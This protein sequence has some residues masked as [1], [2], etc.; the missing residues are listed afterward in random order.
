MNI[1]ITP[2]EQHFDKGYG[3]S[4]WNF[5]ESAKQLSKYEYSRDLSS[6][7]SYLQRHAIELYLKSIIYILHKKYQ[8]PF[9]EAFNLANPAILVKETWKPLSGTHDLVKLYEYLVSVLN[10]CSK[11]LPKNIDWSFTPDIDTKINLI[12][13]Y[14]PKSTYFRY[15][16]S[17]KNNPL[18]QKKST[19]QRV[20]KDSFL[21]DLG[22]STINPVKCTIML[23]AEDNIVDVYDLTVEPL[24]DVKKA[25]G[26]IVEEFHAFH[27]A[28]LAELTRFS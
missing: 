18:D 25:L 7:I 19:V 20:N 13:G 27:C 24:K 5:R 9:G 3:L 14:D 28:I 21:K 26:E 12:N 1:L 4:A 15:P 10:S 6:P 17:S 23:D 2:P 11:L 16:E 22:K 8:I